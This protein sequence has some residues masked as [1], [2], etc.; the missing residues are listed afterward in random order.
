VKK[1]SDEN[2]RYTASLWSSPVWPRHS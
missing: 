2:H 1:L